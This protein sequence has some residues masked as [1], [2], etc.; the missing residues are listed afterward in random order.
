MKTKKCKKC[1]KDL[2]ITNYRKFSVG[3]SNKDGNKYEYFRHECKACENKKGSD[4]S[5]K[6]KRW[7]KDENR[8]KTNIYLKKRFFHTRAMKFKYAAKKRGNFIKEDIT[9]ITKRFASLWRSQKGLCSITG[10]KL[11]KNN[12]WIDHIIPVTRGGSDDIYTNIRWTTKEANKMKS[13]LLDSEFKNILIE[14]NNFFNK[15]GNPTD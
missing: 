11:N 15:Q 1:K 6:N 14:A 12:A 3:I 10:R 7:L 2:P 4:N 5:R 13:N 9:E 8:N